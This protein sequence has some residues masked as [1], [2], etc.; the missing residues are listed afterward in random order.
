MYSKPARLLSYIL[1]LSKYPNLSVFLCTYSVAPSLNIDP[2]KFGPSAAGH[3]A[4]GIILFQ[5]MSRETAV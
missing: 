4:A 1:S 3:T 2:T 5:S